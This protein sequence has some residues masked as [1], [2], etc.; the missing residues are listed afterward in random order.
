MSTTPSTTNE[1]RFSY[2]RSLRLGTFHIGSSFADILGSSIWNYVMANGMLALGGFVATPV[3]LL[4]AMR[5]LLVP[6]TIFTGHLSDTHPILGYRRLP[7]IWIGRGL[8]LLSLPMLPY[9]TSLIFSGNALGWLLAFAG[10]LLYG[11]GTQTSGSPF[12]AL[13]RDS[14]PKDKQGLAYAIVQTILVAAFAFSPLIYARMAR[15]F[16]PNYESDR[17]SLAQFNLDLFWLAT[18]L[19]LLISFI[20]WVGSVIGVEKR[21]RN[22]IARNADSPAQTIAQFKT[23]LG[24]IWADRRMRSFFVLLSIGAISGFGQDG[25][26]EPSLREVFG[27]SFSQSAITTG[28]WGI[29]LLVGLIGCIGLTRKWAT[30]EQT[31]IAL[32]GL[33]LS[34]IGMGLMAFTLLSKTENL[35]TPAVTLFGLGFGIYTAGGSPLLMVMSLDN[36]AGIYLGLWSMAQLLAR[37]VGIALGGIIYDLARLFGFATHV[38]YGAVFALEATGFLI[39]IYFLRASDVHSFARE[40]HI[41]STAALE[42]V[43]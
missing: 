39:C 31:K 36:R 1:P 40:T 20:A 33:V 26:L 27:Y 37:G 10:F 30:V 23:V 38:A 6:L 18:G 16:L 19:A 12:T 29:G 22:A 8:M 42:A 4:L 7:Y 14:A 11:I 9:A 34:S 3:T 25:V 17:S 21:D 24:D 5:Q 41:P 32:I 15:A 43:D 35:M 13:V 2:W 28:F